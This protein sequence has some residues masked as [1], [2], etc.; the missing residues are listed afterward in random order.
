MCNP[1]MKPMEMI[2]LSEFVLKAG[3]FFN[4]KLVLDT[5]KG[6]TDIAVSYNVSGLNAVIFN[7]LKK[8]I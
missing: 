2:C 3:Q 6:I 1:N 5:M 4:S 8:R 7:D